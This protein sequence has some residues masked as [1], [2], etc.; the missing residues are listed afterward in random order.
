[1]KMVA[2]SGIIGIDGVC[3]Y[4]LGALDM[5]CCK[6]DR[7][8]FIHYVLRMRVSYESQNTK[9]ATTTFHFIHFSFVR[10]K[11]AAT[12]PCCSMKENGACS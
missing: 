10:A 1:M 2:E 8:S 5:V 7:V 4:M 12:F 9:S 6:P 3:M 11:G